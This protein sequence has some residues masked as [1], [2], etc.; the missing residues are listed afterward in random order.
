M[1][2]TLLL[3]F[4]L[5]SSLGYSQGI[6]QDFESGGL[7]GTFASA[8]L[9][10]VTREAGPGTNT[11]QVLKFVGNTGS[12]LW[13]GVNIPLTT[14]VNLTP[15]TTRTMTIDVYASEPLLR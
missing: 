10:T 12:A 14:N 3:I 7:G 13:Q 1:K 5:I 15:A 9:P 2:K 6:A 8:G 4:V 11:T